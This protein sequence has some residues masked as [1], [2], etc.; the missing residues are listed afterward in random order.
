MHS[1]QSSSSRGEALGHVVGFV[2]ASV[3][4]CL[5]FNSVEQ[6]TFCFIQLIYVL[7]SCSVQELE[8]NFWMQKRNET[9][10]D[11][12]T[13][14]RKKKAHTLKKALVWYEWAQGACLN[15]SHRESA[16]LGSLGLELTTL[17][18]AETRHC[19]ALARPDLCNDWQDI[20]IL[21]L[22]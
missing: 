11:V 9:P 20:L 1:C 7:S 13:A 8:Y 6:V 22:F 4:C 15:E 17:W 2:N 14:R 21:F 3:N 5:N 16:G 19:R 18:A 10:G 12:V